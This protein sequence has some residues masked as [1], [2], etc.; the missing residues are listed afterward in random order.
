[1]VRFT[2]LILPLK[3]EDIFHV[4]HETVSVNLFSKKNKKKNNEKKTRLHFPV[5]ESSIIFRQ[6][7]HSFIGGLSTAEQNYSF[8]R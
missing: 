7:R 5:D 8:F 3:P 2:F 6:F 4:R 1:M